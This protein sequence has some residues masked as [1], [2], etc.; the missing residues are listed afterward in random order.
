MFMSRLY[1]L[2]AIVL[3]CACDG[4]QPPVSTPS[5]VSA[6]P[7][8]PAPT[9]PA[10][11]SPAPLQDVERGPVR[12]S[13]TGF[14]DQ[15]GQPWQYR[16]V[17]SFML[18]HRYL[19]GESVDGLLEAYRTLGGNTVRVWGMVWWD[20]NPVVLHLVPSD[21]GESYW[22]K[23]SSFA[24][25]VAS[26]GMRVEFSI[27]SDAGRIMPDQGAEIR[28]A[29]R[30]YETLANKWN[31]FVEL[32]NECELNGVTPSRFPSTSRVL[33]SA[34]SGGGGVVPPTIWG[35]LTYHD[36]RASDWYQ[37]VNY[38]SVGVPVVQDE[39]MGAADSPISGKRDNN[40]AH[41]YEFG[42]HV[43]YPGATFHS[44]S[45]LTADYPSA[46][47][48]ECGRQLFLGMRSK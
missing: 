45:G 43:K 13:G 14:V 34:G 23:L 38:P 17:S 36:N 8:A 31:V 40:P 15:S 1:P 24:D 37:H 2:A 47:E 32:C 19:E 16:G 6:A 4:S 20:G 5:T 28:F 33:A 12:I 26:H 39:P 42:T 30:V 41:F 44:S 11:P 3:L 18:F 9:P 35:F 10:A 48:A 29:D 22:A 46:T 7:A 21:Y 27:F 25:L